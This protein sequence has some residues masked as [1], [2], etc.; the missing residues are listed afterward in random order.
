MLRA[1]ALLVTPVAA[2]WI[3]ACG[4]EADASDVGDDATTLSFTSST[5]AGHSHSFTL[6][7]TELEMPP[8]AGVTSDTSPSGGHTHSVSLG[9]A[10][11]EAIRDGQTVTKTSSVSGGH[12][13]TFVFRRVDGTDVDD[14]RYD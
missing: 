10:E 7:V 14:G 3:A 8:A 6:S 4:D 9:V 2:R 13:H 12:A 1:G 11:L 5:D